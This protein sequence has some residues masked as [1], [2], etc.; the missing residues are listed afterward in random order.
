MAGSPSS[1]KLNNNSLLNTLHQNDSTHSF[2]DGGIDWLPILG[3]VNNTAV[4]VGAQIVPRALISFPLDAYLDRGPPD[5][6]A[7]PI[8][9]F[10]AATILA[11]VMFAPVYLLVT[12]APFSSHPHQH[13][14][15]VFLVIAVPTCMMWYLT[16]VSVCTSLLIIDVEHHPVYSLAICMSSFEKYVFRSSAHLKNRVICLLA[17]ELFEYLIYSKY[18]LLTKCMVCRIL[19]YILSYIFFKVIWRYHHINSSNPWTWNIC[20]LFV[21]SSI[22][23]INKCLTVFSLWVFY[24]L[25]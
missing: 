20:P 2:V 4:N 18:L 24:L 1:L 21:S 19:S 9:V 14:F 12:K 25:G 17:V 11:S 15:F 23:F 10:G 5:H 3:V 16:V 8:P 13:F 6:T 22:S 7:A